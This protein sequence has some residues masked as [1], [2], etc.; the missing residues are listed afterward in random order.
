MAVRKSDF[1]GNWYPASPET[2]RREIQRWGERARGLSTKPEKTVGGL[3]PHAGWYYS[4]EIACNVFKVLSE[5]STPRTVVI[6]GMHLGPT[7]DHVVMV[8]GAW[9]TPLGNIE[10]DETLSHALIKS[11]RFVEETPFHH[12]MDNTIEVQLPFIKHFFPESL[13]LPIGVASRNEALEI[14]EQVARLAMEMDLE[15]IVV[16][17]TD[18]THYGPNYGF[19]A[20][21]VGEEAVRWVKENNDKRMTDLMVG[22]DAR[23]ALEEGMASQNACCAGAVAAAIAATEKLG[24]RR[25]ELLVYRTS[26][27]VEPHT[28]FVGY[29]GVVYSY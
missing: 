12:G 27:D 16:G 8:E 17:S 11:F 29:A 28:S 13:I 2:C 20:K 4:G 14:G 24:A 15:I 26:Y 10:I 7:S 18:L 19:T 1:V 9:E 3:V 5:S 6:F 25:G 23:A 21:G 22:M